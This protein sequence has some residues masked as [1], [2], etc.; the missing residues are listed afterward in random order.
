MKELVCKDAKGLFDRALIR[1]IETTLDEIEEQAAMAAT[2]STGASDDGPLP[3]PP[4]PVQNPESA[5]TDPAV[6][7]PPLNV[8]IVAAIAPTA[9]VAVVSC[10]NTHWLYH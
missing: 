10:P 4:L 7:L 3:L 9:N 2:T 6:E 8:H 1:A 5:S